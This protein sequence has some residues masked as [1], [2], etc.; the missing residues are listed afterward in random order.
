MTN[1]PPPWTPRQLIAM[2]DADSHDFAIDGI[3]FT[4]LAAGTAEELPHRGHG[5]GGSDA[6]ERVAR[7]G[8]EVSGPPG[9]DGERRDGCGHTD[10]ADGADDRAAD[11]QRLLAREQR[12]QPVRV[13]E[14]RP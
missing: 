5:L 10:V 2:A 14:A 6:T 7:V 8:A 12:H 9:Q 11:R 13:R 4:P 3:V 1:V